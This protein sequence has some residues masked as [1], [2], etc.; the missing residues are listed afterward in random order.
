MDY[1]YLLGHCTEVTD[2]CHQ[3]QHA[4]AMIH[5]FVGELD[6]TAAVMQ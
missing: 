3:H 4:A 5:Q 1:I 2:V 6:Y